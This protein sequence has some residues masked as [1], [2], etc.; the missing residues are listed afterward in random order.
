MVNHLLLIHHLADTGIQGSALDWLFPV[1]QGWGQRVV[2]VKQLFQRHPWFAECHK[3]QLPPQCYLT[4]IC[5]PLPILPRG[6]GWGVTNMQTTPSSMCCLGDQ[7][8]YVPEALQAMAGWFRLSQLKL[9][10]MKMEVLY[11]SCGSL[12]QGISSLIFDQC[13]SLGIWKCSYMPL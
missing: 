13:Q 1:L 7:L 3:G 10:P 11:I 5:N 2:L 9:N 4:S 8:G 12:R 6:M